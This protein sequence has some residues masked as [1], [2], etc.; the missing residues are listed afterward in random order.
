V[1]WD[2]TWG[3]DGQTYYGQTKALFGK[4]CSGA[5]PPDYDES[6][7]CWLRIASTGAKDCRDP[8]GLVDACGY[9]V[10]CTSHTWVG[11]ALAAMIIIDANG[12]TG[13]ELWNHDA[14]FDYI[15]RWVDVEGGST[16]SSF[17]GDMWNEYR[18]QLPEEWVSPDRLETDTTGSYNKTDIQGSGTFTWDSTSERGYIQTG[19][20]VQITVDANLLGID[21]AGTFSFDLYVEAVY[22]STISFYVDLMQDATNFYRLGVAGDATGYR[23]YGIEKFVDGYETADDAN[24]NTTTHITEGQTYSFTFYVSPTS[25]YVT[26]NGGTKLTIDT[27]TT[28][29]TLNRFLFMVYQGDVYLDNIIWCDT[30]CQFPCTDGWVNDDFSLDTTACYTTRQTSA[31]DGT[32]TF[33]WDGNEDCFCDTNCIGDANGLMT[34]FMML[35]STLRLLLHKGL[36]VVNLNLTSSS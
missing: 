26:I 11:E 27:E 24:K 13:K 19:D 2:S 18:Q 15:D 9:R 23:D 14:L 7:G 6:S 30:L 25:S 33:V 31:G 28:S 10:C 4:S 34:T 17:I 1:D 8:R 12:N 21:S 36:K 20:N 3:E 29:F 5:T 16:G 22:P 32:S 35:I